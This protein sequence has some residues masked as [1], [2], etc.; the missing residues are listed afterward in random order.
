MTCNRRE[1]HPLRSPTLFFKIIL[2]TSLQDGKLKIP[3]K[4][5]KEYGANLSNP[6]FLKPADG[7]EWKVYWTKHD[8]GIWFQKGWKKFAT[9]YSLSHGHLV[10]FKYQETCHLEVHI[11]DQSAL[12]ISY[13][14]HGTKNENDNLDHISDDCVEILDEMTPSH[15]TELKSTTSCP[16]PRKKLRTRSSG[17]V[18]QSSNLPRHV[19]FTNGAMQEADKFTSKNPFFTF[20]IKSNH[21]GHCRPRVPIAFVSKYFHNK[22][23]VTLQF[24]KKLWDV[25]LIGNVRLKLSRGWAQFAKETKLRA[26]D[27]CVFELINKVGAVLD[28]HIFRG[29]P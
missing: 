6:V 26:G 25:K 3:N 9:Y 22:H 18:G 8:S 11:F 29:H 16:Q 14:F 5:T 17:N 19:Q 24:E 2:N 12:E 20:N 21:K 13:P 7:T 4:F 28:V 23:I 15:K 27:S 1:K 10:L